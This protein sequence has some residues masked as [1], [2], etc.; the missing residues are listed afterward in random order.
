MFKKSFWEE[1]RKGIKIGK[2]G[3]CVVLDNKNFL[4]E[5]RKD[6]PDSIDLELWTEFELKVGNCEPFEI[7]ELGRTAEVNYVPNFST[8]VGGGG[9]DMNYLGF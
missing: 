3:F 7:F 5:R 4:S 2:A 6:G 1:I 9:W 8:G